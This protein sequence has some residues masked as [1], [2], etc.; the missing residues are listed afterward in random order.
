MFVADVNKPRKSKKLNVDGGE[1]ATTSISH[2][3]R[4]FIFTFRCVSRSALSKI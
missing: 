3:V 4:N 2:L 1:N